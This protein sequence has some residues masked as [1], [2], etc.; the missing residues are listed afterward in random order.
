MAQTHSILRFITTIAMASVLLGFG[1]LRPL[2]G[3]G[4]AHAVPSRLL[5]L[6]TPHSL[7]YPQS[8]TVVS[9]RKR[10]TR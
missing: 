8:Y 2:A 5:H 4:V 7:W 1:A 10:V 9:V 3:P 6:D